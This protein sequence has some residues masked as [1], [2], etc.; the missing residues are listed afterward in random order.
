[1]SPKAEKRKHVRGEALLI[2][3][4]SPSGD[5]RGGGGALLRERS[6]SQSGEK[7]YDPAPD[8]RPASPGDRFRSPEKSAVKRG[9]GG[10]AAEKSS[11][12]EKTGSFEKT[13][14]VMEKTISKQLAEK[15]VSKAMAS[16]AAAERE[17]ERGPDERGK[18]RGPDEREKERGL[19][20]KEKKRTPDE[21][22]RPA[23]RKRGPVEREKERGPAG[24]QSSVEYRETEITS[25]S[26]DELEGKT[27]EGA[28]RTSDEMDR[29][30]Q[31][32][33]EEVE[34]QAADIVTRA[35]EE[36]VA[37]P[38]HL[39]TKPSPNS[40]PEG[41]RRAALAGSE[42]ERDRKHVEIARGRADLTGSEE[43]RDRKHVEIAKGR[44]DLTGSEDERDRKRSESGNPVEREE[45]LRSWGVTQK[46]TQKDVM[47]R[48]TAD[49]EGEDE[50][51]RRT[52]SR[53][54]SPTTARDRGTI[55]GGSSPSTGRERGPSPRGPSPTTGRERGASPRGPS[56]TTGGERRPSPRGPSPVSAVVAEAPPAT[57]EQTEET[58][59]AAAEPEEEEAKIKEDETEELERSVEDLTTALR[60]LPG[61]AAKPTLKDLPSSD[62]S[63]FSSFESVKLAP[64]MGGKA[65]GAAEAAP[66]ETSAASA[67]GRPAPAPVPAAP[68]PAKQEP[69]SNTKRITDDVTDEPEVVETRPG[70]DD[71][72]ENAQ[73]ATKNGNKVESY[74]KRLSQEMDVAANGE[75]GAGARPKRPPPLRGKTSSRAGDSVVKRLSQELE[76]SM[77]D[78]PPPSPVT[79]VFSR[80]AS[81]DPAPPPDDAARRS[82]SRDGADIPAPAAWVFGN[83]KRSAGDESP[84]KSSRESSF[85]SQENAPVFTPARKVAEDE[86]GEVAKTAE[87][88]EDTADDTEKKMSEETA[89]SNDIKDGGDESG[90]RGD[91]V[92]TPPRRG[93]GDQGESAGGTGRAPGP[94]V[95]P[96]RQGSVETKPGRGLQKQGSAETRAVAE[97]LVTQAVQDSAKVVFTQA[98]AQPPSPPAEPPPPPAA[99]PP[100]PPA[101]KPPSPPAAKPPSPPA[102]KPPS[103]PP[104]KKAPP[105]VAKKPSRP[106]SQEVKSPTGP[107]AQQAPGDPT[108]AAAGRRPP[109]AVLPKPKRRV[110]NTQPSNKALEENRN[111]PPESTA[112]VLSTKDTDAS[113]KNTEVM[114]MESGEEKKDS[115]EKE[116]CGSDVITGC[117]PQSEAPT[118]TNQCSAMT[119]STEVTVEFARP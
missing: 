105:P 114:A 75:N 102:A 24:R 112:E 34:R 14:S 2:D 16:E 92:T 5:G 45:V 15:A 61:G 117:G 96:P 21:E 108:L 58:A 106:P 81:L 23:A 103:P 59:E 80:A 90:S 93:S 60:R 62:S 84:L 79:A 71:S 50:L 119:M 85:D 9:A 32:W 30:G 42:E 27:E 111:K 22:R 56:P 101:A 89:G 40:P 19:D 86:S 113:T 64:H 37:M 69:E 29:R 97:K 72:T 98:P 44:A 116:K 109:P 99:K 57:D 82:L 6:R 91:H 13:A 55:P 8:P 35:I 107:P 52:S 70:R 94:P 88:A 18:E 4:D 95:K 83:R 7:A 12:L 77:A 33:V 53:G 67:A 38:R 78:Y 46:P 76:G 65:P 1:M 66:A 41:A 49:V 39:L 36:A 63:S 115:P 48:N 10:G 118:V 73:A 11:F 28:G 100:S 17:K 110:E 74:V 51:G 43:E 68:A 104:Q 26:A 31:R 3:R 47:A 25:E 87:T 20:G 54:P